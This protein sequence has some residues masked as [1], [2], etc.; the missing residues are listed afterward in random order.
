MPSALL[1]TPLEV[2]AALRAEIDSAAMLL[3][4]RAEFALGR[5]QAGLEALERL[6]KVHPETD[7]AISSYLNEAEYYA[8]QDKIAE[9]R[10]S[11][12]GLIDNRDYKDSEHVPYALYRLALQLQS[13]SREHGRA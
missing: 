13:L 1:A 7:A 12:V 5:E 4:A 9:A 8:A 6:R 3:K 11:L 2:D 10:K